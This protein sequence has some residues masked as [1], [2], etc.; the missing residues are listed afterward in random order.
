MKKAISLLFLI[1]A[2]LTI[3][4]TTHAYYRSVKNP[5]V[6]KPWRYHLMQENIKPNPPSKKFSPP[7]GWPSWI[8]YDKALSVNDVWPGWIEQVL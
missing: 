1:V 5:Y 6:L 2:F 4:T 8:G 3:T 7:S